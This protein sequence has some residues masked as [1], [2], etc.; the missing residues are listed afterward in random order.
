MPNE[1]ICETDKPQLPVRAFDAADIPDG[2]RRAELRYL[3]LV[4]AILDGLIAR[5]EAAN[6]KNL[7]DMYE[8]R[9]LLLDE[10]RFSL[11]DGED[12]VNMLTFDDLV[13]LAGFDR[14]ITESDNRYFNG[15][16]LL[17]NLRRMK[18]APYFGRMDFLEDGSQTPEKIYIGV[19]SLYDEKTFAF[20]VYDWRAPISSMYYDCGPGRA[21]FSAPDGEITGE[22][23]GKRQYKITGG[24][25]RY[26]FDS[27]LV[28]DD[29]ILMYELSKPSAAAVKPVINSIQRA[30]NRAIRYDRLDNLL[31]FGIAGS[32][33]TTVG[34]HRLAYLLYK[35]RGSIRSGD[36]RIFSNN[37]VF[38]S[39]ISGII[40]ELGEE[41]VPMLDF[42]DLIE[43]H[44]PRRFRYKDMYEQIESLG[45]AP[46][47]VRARG[48]V[49]KY[50]REFLDYTAGYV[51][52]YKVRFYDIYFYDF[53]ICRAEELEELYR[54][55]TSRSDMRL[56]TERVLGYLTE[57]LETFIDENKKEVVAALNRRS[58]DFVSKNCCMQM[59][60]NFK[61]TTLT[62]ISALA[63]PDAAQL[64]RKL[65]GEYGGCDREIYAKTAASLETELDFEDILVIFYI[66]IIKGGVGKDASVKHVLIDEAQD[67]CL[68]QHRIIRALH[69]AGR[70]T[71]LADVNQAL[72]GLINI[73][74]REEL[75][76][77]YSGSRGKPA[78]MELEK[79][80]RQTFELARFASGILGVFSEERYFRRHGGEPKLIRT[81]GPAAG[82]EDAIADALAEI[83]EKGFS[84]VGILTERRREA[85]ELY[86]RLG[87]RAAVSLITDADAKFLPGAVVM[88]IAYAK[89]LEFDAVIVPR[90]DRLSAAEN[91]RILYLM[92]TRALHLLYLIA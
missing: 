33:K 66:E 84:S 92:C 27:D 55:R 28:I 7:A 81:G 56:K 15:S 47:G 44:M 22:I 8:D 57:K 2:E 13:N 52:A 72:Y 77:V 25:M 19:S 20:Y 18:N 46:G 76:G 58:D 23:A 53:P 61:N 24:Q 30:Q 89:G 85:E 64:Y 11:G 10:L 43:A 74:D 35:Y 3:A 38:N 65:L 1:N 82:P 29:D 42:C 14:F 59:F 63:N 73:A 71:V 51:R 70:Y 21:A 41:S 17:G 4:G 69:P 39:Y 79:S 67:L 45:E 60:E 90:Y 6:G 31:I 54:D 16:L 68:L 83:F 86:G 32:G 88:P 37:N 49:L 34:L 62:E 12:S 36:I 87:E 26:M 5:Q 78:V 40:P 75:A 80:Y 48:V 50:S 91:K 9:K